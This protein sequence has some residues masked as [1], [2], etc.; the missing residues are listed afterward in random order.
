[1]APNCIGSRGYCN[2]VSS[3]GEVRE[4]D[5]TMII[6]PAVLT[7]FRMKSCEAVRYLLKLDEGWPSSQLPVTVFIDYQVRENAYV[8]HVR[9]I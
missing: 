7:F 9:T 2:F 6:L 5:E 8:K 1:M 3:K 4:I